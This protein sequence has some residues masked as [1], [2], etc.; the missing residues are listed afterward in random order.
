V[1]LLVSDAAL[2]TEA[3][4]KGSR[5]K[6]LRGRERQSSKRRCGAVKSLRQGE[7]DDGEGWKEGWM[8]G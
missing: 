3:A 8:D 1:D 6:E 5:R 2:E 7:D 4:M